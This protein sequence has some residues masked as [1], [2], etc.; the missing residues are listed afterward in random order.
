MADYYLEEINETREG[1]NLDAILE[2][3]LHHDI[4]I[5]RGEDFQYICYIDRKVYS[6]ALTP[7]CALISGIN[8]YK[9]I[10]MEFKNYRRTQIAEMHE[11]NPDMMYSK[12]FMDKISIS[13]EDIKNGSPKKGDM[14]ARNPKN[15]ND[16]WLVAE[17][18]FKD[19]FEQM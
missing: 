9:T 10:K 4:Q 5:I 6:V 19:N 3:Q 18:Y 7:M 12:E 17:Q 11:Y 1:F 15:H 16:M 8:E 2:F 13:Q 14:I